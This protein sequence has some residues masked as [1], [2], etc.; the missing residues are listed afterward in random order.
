MKKFQS[1]VEEWMLR[2]FGSEVLMNKKERIHRFMEEAMEL[3]QSLG[4]TLEEAK[5]MMDYVWSRPEGDPDQEVGGVMHCL[6]ALCT[7]NEISL[8]QASDEILEYCEGRSGSILQKHSNKPDS[9]V[10]I[11]K[12]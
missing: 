4:Y 1:N 5:T 2:V 3:A 9:I 10:S 11:K 6:A 7:A 8:Q 12:K